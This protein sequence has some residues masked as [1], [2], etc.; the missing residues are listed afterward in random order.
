ML[1]LQDAL[2]REVGRGGIAVI[3]REVCKPP[4]EI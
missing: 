2:S 3:R 1:K 4:I